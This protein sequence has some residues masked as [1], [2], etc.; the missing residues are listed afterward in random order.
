MT[1]AEMSKAVSGLDPADYLVE[2]SGPSIVL[3]HSSM[4]SKSQWRE[5]VSTF[6]DRFRVIA[7]DLYGYGSAPFPD[8]GDAFSLD[9]E[10]RRID[11]ILKSLLPSTEKF[12]LVGHS[13][14][15]AIGLRFALTR[16][17]KLVSLTLFEPTAFYLLD[18]KDVGLIEIVG[19]I[20]DLKAM[21]GRGE[22]EAA[23]ARFV[24]YW[25][26]VGAFAEL[27]ET[28][29]RK[30]MEQ[31]Q[32]VM[33]DFH[34]LLNESSLV[35]EYRRLIVPV[36]LIGGEFSTRSVHRV[37]DVLARVLAT[38]CQLNWVAA[39]HMAPVTHPAEVNVVIDHF[40]RRVEK[41]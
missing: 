39:S 8:H 16:P 20:A 9:F 27:P 13:Y 21:L 33:Y 31:I 28:R 23:T 29:Q 32:K 6:R 15:G 38:R 22:V 11:S 37:L 1:R 5:F 4:A 14:G 12:H 2:G 24:D 34:A 41:G 36:C 10:A 30:L 26:G 40:I 18:P 17:E 25:N 7:I 19:L 35:D 3:L